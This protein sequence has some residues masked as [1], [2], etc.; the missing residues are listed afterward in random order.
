MLTLLFW[1]MNRR[2]RTRQ[3][4]NLARKHDV[5]ILVLAECYDEPSIL[6]GLNQQNGQLRY[7]AHPYEGVRVSIFTCVPP[8]QFVQIEAKPHYRIHSFEKP[9]S[10][11]LLT[12]TVHATSAL[13]AKEKDRTKQIEKLAKRIHE[14]EDSQGHTR[15]LLIG[16]LNSQPFASQV[17][18]ADGL[19]AVMSRQIAKEESRRVSGEDYRFF[20]NPCWKFF[21]N[22]EPNPQG[23]Y[24]YRKSEHD[25]DFWYTLDQFM[26]RPELMQ[27]LNDDDVRILTDDGETSFVK[28]KNG[29]PNSKVASDHF[30]IL[31][32]LNYPGA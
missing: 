14:V 9:N 22:R 26:I 7:F 2:P 15:T 3:C 19:H 31:A 28:K 8:E 11:Q 24:F 25:I 21:A 6:R 1:N 29:I 16:D 30:P 5:D 17:T 13:R 27:Y 32:K 23:T 20:Y 12:V 4:V 10:P 18:S